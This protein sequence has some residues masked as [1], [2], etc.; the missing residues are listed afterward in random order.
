MRQAMSLYVDFMSAISSRSDQNFS[1]E[2]FTRQNLKLTE[3]RSKT[4]SKK[5][6]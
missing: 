5:Q 4:A 2:V 6:I 3:K 1:F